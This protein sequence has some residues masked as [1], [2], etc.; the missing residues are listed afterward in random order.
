MDVRLV[1]RPAKRI[2]S[3]ALRPASSPTAIA[4]P[5]VA[6]RTPNPLPIVAMNGGANR[7][8]LFAPTLATV[9]GVSARR[10]ST[11]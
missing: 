11:V 3:G 7:I 8:A 5:I 6:R 10:T 1:N 4:P 9:N 2:S